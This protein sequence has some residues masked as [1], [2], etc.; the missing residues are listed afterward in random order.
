MR[1]IS[2]YCKNS[3]ELCV[4][5]QRAVRSEYTMLHINGALSHPQYM[6]IMLGL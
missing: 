6:Y 4:S 3:I 5:V 2:P 1:D